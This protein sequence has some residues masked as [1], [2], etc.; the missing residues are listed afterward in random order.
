MFEGGEITFA[1]FEMPR[2]YVAR[3]VGHDI[4]ESAATMD[5]LRERIREALALRFTDDDRPG[6]VRL[7]I[8]KAEHGDHPR[9]SGE[10]DNTC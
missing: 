7:H 10:G 4:T 3:A 9:S 1:V 5:E 8:A 2:G 6:A